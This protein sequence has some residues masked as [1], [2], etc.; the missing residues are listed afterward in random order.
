MTTH[1]E[2]SKEAARRF[3]QSALIVD[4]DTCAGR[5]RW[6]GSGG[7]IGPEPPHGPSSNRRLRVR[8]RPAAETPTADRAK[9]KMRS[10]P[11]R[12]REAHGVVC[13]P[14][15]PLRVTKALSRRQHARVGRR[16]WHPLRHRD[17]RLAHRFQRPF[18]YSLAP[19]GRAHCA[20]QEP[21]LRLAPRFTRAIRSWARLRTP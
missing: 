11:N 6:R 7:T 14:R 18:G 5:F 16:R 20:K 21:R 19:V 2:R 17:P 1:L 15:N 13:Q 9:R 4:D 3:L 8:L 12:P 10:N